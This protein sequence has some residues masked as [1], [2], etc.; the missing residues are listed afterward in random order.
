LRFIVQFLSWN[1]QAARSMHKD[2]T[3]PRAIVG[4]GEF[5]TSPGKTYLGDILS[6][7]P[8]KSTVLSFKL[9][10]VMIDGLVG[11]FSL[12]LPSQIASTCYMDV[13]PWTLGL[14]TPK[15]S[16]RFNSKDIDV[17]FTCP[18]VTLNCS[19]ISSRNAL[20]LLV[21]IL[22]QIIFPQLSNNRSLGCLNALP[23]RQVLR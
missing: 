8:C 11:K 9:N 16:K 3:R 4:G 12:P 7:L 17:C 2:D 13:L 23:S 6:I 14:L 10:Q 22:Y 15:P 19:L 20:Q 5:S 18:V 21:R 1:N